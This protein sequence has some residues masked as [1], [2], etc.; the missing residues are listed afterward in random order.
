[1]RSFGQFSIDGFKGSI[2]LLRFLRDL[3]NDQ[4]EILTHLTGNFVFITGGDI[5]ESA[6]NTTISDGIIVKNGLIYQFQGGTY[7][8]TPATL[9]VLF[10]TDTDSQYPMPYFVGDPNPKDIYLLNFAKV[11]ATGTVALD[12]FIKISDIKSL[13]T[14]VET[15]LDA[16]DDII[17]ELTLKADKGGYEDLTGFTINTPKLGSIL[18]PIVREYD[19]G[20]INVRIFIA[21]GTGQSLTTSDWIMRGLPRMGAAGFGIKLFNVVFSDSLGTATPGLSKVVC[22]ERQDGDSNHSQ[23]RLY[24]GAPLTGE[25]ALYIDIDY[26]SS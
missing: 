24:S 22:I 16:L 6:G 18:T 26:Y 13:S 3:T 21:T 15:I 17:T 8:G 11:D 2:E 23:I 20:L 19:S 5:T 1:M 7:L 25:Q 4:F 9:N 14:S 12:Q 10:S